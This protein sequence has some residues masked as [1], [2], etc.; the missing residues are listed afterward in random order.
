MALIDVGHGLE[1]GSTF[2]ALTIEEFSPI[3]QKAEVPVVM[4]RDASD[5]TSFAVGA[6]LKHP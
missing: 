6:G 4:G 3:D 1:Q 5:R 2:P